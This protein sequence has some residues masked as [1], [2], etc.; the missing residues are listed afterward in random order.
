MDSLR[1]IDDWRKETFDEIIDVRSPAEY[2]IDH[3]P[4][5]SNIAILND[6][7]RSL[8]GTLYKTNSFK[9]KVLGASLIS[10]NISEILKNNLLEKKGSWNCLIYCWRGGQ[11]SRSLALVLNEI[12]WRV[13]ILSGG[14]KSFRRI[15]RNELE[16]LNGFEFYIL[17]AQTGT[18]KTKILECLKQ[19]GAQVLNLE[20]LANHRG[21][22][23]GRELNQKQPN[24]KFFESKIHS[25]ISKFKNDKPVF[26]EAESSK[27]GKLHLPIS[28]WKELVNSKRIKI[29]API[30]KRVSFLLE[31]YQHLIENPSLLEPFI[32]G[33]KNRFS[34]K[35]I[36]DWELM[37]KNNNW[38]E[39]VKSILENHYDPSYK[40]SEN[41][42]SHLI[43]N[44]YNLTDLSNEEICKISNK[45]IKRIQN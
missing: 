4:G 1:I 6:E 22:L 19:M 36:V 39:F 20:E 26:V 35:L 28:L 29:K 23:L 43:T 44:K 13:T 3:I 33:M 37:I 5:S 8:V 17:Q 11:R 34:K 12:G 15:I 9:A 24:Q 2:F 27:I 32:K 16:N 41:K 31:D 18:A 30:N 21:S 25:I 38:S 10:K 42:Y 45:I 14:Y 7:E 40:H